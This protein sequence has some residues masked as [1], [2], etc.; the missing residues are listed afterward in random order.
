MMNKNIEHMNLLVDFAVGG[1]CTVA[2]TV[3]PKGIDFLPK[4]EKK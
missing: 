2:S 3:V 1:R 4:D